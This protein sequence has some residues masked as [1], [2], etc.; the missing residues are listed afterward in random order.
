M[1]KL[2]GETVTPIEDILIKWIKT[3]ANEMKGLLCDVKWNKEKNGV[4]LE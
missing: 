1:C 4:L 2:V 3:Y